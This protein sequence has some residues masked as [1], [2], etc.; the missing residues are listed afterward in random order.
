M[1][2]F[3][4]IQDKLSEKILALFNKSKAGDELECVYNSKEH[5]T[6]TKYINILQ[7]W[8]SNDGFHL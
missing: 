2:N 3:D 7:R 8:D 4:Y 5:L 1:Y 6:R